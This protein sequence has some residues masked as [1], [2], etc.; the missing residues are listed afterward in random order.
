[1]VMDWK[2]L[3]PALLVAAALAGI[4]MFTRG[5]SPQGHVVDL[6]GH[7]QVSVVLTDQGFEPA[8]LR[9]N[10]GTTV[11]FSTTR[12]RP[13]W[14]ASNAHPSHDIF[15]EFDPKVPI[16]PDKTWSFTFDRVGDW[17]MHDH[18]RSYFTGIVY[19]VE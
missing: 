1:M 16:D 6:R 18:V 4:F 12:G 15:P 7:S 8:Y 19:V 3:L 17:G 11:T 14:P 9:I 2:K 10:R 5:S 13:F